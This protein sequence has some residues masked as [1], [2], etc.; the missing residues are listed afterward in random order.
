MA[1]N[2][3]ITY[4]SK[5]QSAC[6]LVIAPDEYITHWRKPVVQLSLELPLSDE[7]YAIMDT[8][9]DF[10]HQL[11]NE[12]STLKTYLA[13]QPEKTGKPDLII[14]RIDDC[15][16]LLQKALENWSEVEEIVLG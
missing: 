2:C 13:N 3:Y 10:V 14:G 8:Q 4:K 15:T 1:I 6:I 16:R 5:K 12:L 11:L 7:Y 9:A